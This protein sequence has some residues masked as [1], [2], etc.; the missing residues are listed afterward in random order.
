MQLDNGSEGARLNLESYTVELIQARIS[1][2][3]DLHKAV[4]I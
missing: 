2:D 1:G 4:G 3:L